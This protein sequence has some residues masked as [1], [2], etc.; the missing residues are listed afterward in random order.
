MGYCLSN[1]LDQIWYPGPMTHL[2]NIF[3]DDDETHC[4][5]LIIIQEDVEKNVGNRPLCNLLTTQVLISLRICAGW[6]G[7]MLPTYRINGYCSIY[8]Q[9]E[10]V[11]IRPLMLTLTGTF[12]V[13]IWR[14][15]LFLMLHITYPPCYHYSSL[16]WIRY[17]CSKKLLRMIWCFTSLSTLFVIMSWLMIMKSSVQ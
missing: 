11:Q 14:K 13:H 10:N 15:G 4:M 8:W 17:F 2:F 3:L 16:L 5:C 12:V 9:T 1:Y 6:S 7:T